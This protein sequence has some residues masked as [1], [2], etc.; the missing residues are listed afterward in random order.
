MGRAA[1]R[2]LLA[3][4]ALVT[5]FAPRAAGAQV[6]TCVEVEA[7]SKE[8][9]E[10]AR[11]VKSE[12]DRHPSHHA[13]DH[14]CQGT[15][16][17]EVIELGARDGAWITARLNT[18]VPH[19]EKVGP[20]GLVPAVERLL[21]VVLNNDPLVLVAPGSQ[22]WLERQRH[23][24]EVRS[25]MHWGPEVYE[26]GARVGTS[27]GTLSGFALTLRRE[28]STLYI[29][30]RL[31]GAI[32]PGGAL[33][34]LHLRM[35]VD[36]QVE[37]GAYASPAEGTSLFA[38]ALVGLVY[39][40]FEGPAPLDGPGAVGTATSTA[41]SLAV[42]GGVEALRT[43]DVRVLAFVQLEAPVSASRDTD[44]GVISQWIPS[45]SLGAGL[46]F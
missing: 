13:T 23:A 5:L 20:D 4:G 24:L 32:D 9:D 39:Q 42:R 8:K 12:L 16:T 30:T 31:G 45:V 19:R 33:A 2:G 37:A 40:R 3:L 11:L 21:R 44:H 26:I 46:L 25:R 27:L 22:S 35:Q 14:D 1:V 29:G 34:A 17:I 36:A 43:S 6:R 41:L 15:L 28:A 38:S 7:P 18:Q 10:V